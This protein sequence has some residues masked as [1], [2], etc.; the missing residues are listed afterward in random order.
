MQDF[1]SDDFENEKEAEIDLSKVY[2]FPDELVIRKYG[3]AYLVIYTKGISWLVLDSDEE[4][5]V[6]QLLKDGHS[7]EQV[8]KLAKEVNV[9]NVIAQIEAKHFEHPINNEKTDRNI[10]IYL[11]NRCNEHCRHCYMYAGD[12]DFKELSP[13]QWINVLDD[14]RKNGGTGVTFT[15]GEVTVYKCFDKVIRHAHEVGLKVT[16]LSNGIQWKEDLIH[17]LSACIDEIQI[18]IDGYDAKSYYEV[19]RFDGFSRAIQCVDNFCESGTKVSIAVTPL[20]DNLSEFVAKF[21]PFAKKLMKKHPDV[22]I[23]FNNELIPGR[24]INVTKE[25]NDKYRQL[26]RQLVDR[27]YPDFYI[28]NYVLNYENHILR[29]NCG[30]GEISIAA[31]G[32][33]F[34]CSRI[35]ELKSSFNILDKSFK[36]L[37]VRSDEIIKNTSVDNTEGCK[38]CDVRYICGGGCR[39]KYKGINDVDTH[40]GEWQYQCEG[41]DLIYDKMIKS[42]KYFFE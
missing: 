15:G 32:Q 22:F 14:F 1:K 24:E 31:N 33:V 6:F 2:S 19:R 8:L 41:K 26:V 39:I 28:K 29:R 36:E 37:F 35:H 42:N 27:L 20:Y 18:S 16:V 11:T 4:L 40:V 34:W 23:K 38:E 12:E 25:E 7:I 10:Y 3:E 17:D 9:V 13:D 21:E 30:F 5:K